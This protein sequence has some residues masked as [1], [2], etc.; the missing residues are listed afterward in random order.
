MF[1]WIVVELLDHIVF[2][3]FWR[4]SI[5]FS[6]VAVPIYIATKSVQGPHFLHI[7]HS[8]YHLSL[9]FLMIAILT[10]MRWYL[11]MVLICI[12]LMINDFKHLFMYLLAIHISSLE[13]V[14]ILCSF[15][16]WTVWFF[17]NELHAFLYILNIDP[18]QIV[19]KYLSHYRLSFHFVSFA[20]KK[21][22]VWC[23]PSCLFFISLIVL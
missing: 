11:T 13:N 19:C 6:T 8:I 14:H 22:F 16:N 10:S 15:Y 1:L 18:L 12:F 2:L 9:L 20:V 4:T 3:I 21:L 17:V 23:G 5:L 7:H